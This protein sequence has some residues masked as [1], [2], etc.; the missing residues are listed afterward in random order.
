MRMYEV[1]YDGI[2]LGMVAADK[3]NVATRAYNLATG[4][5]V[6]TS[7]SLYGRV[8]DR[9]LITYND[10]NHNRYKHMM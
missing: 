8:I 5:T 9:K 4:C 7:G 3:T 6:A 1:F 2:K 10:Q